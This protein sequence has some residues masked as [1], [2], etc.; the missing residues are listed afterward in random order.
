MSRIIIYVR[1]FQYRLLSNKLTTNILRNK[2]DASVSHLCT[3]CN[4]E[5]EYVD[6]LLYDCQIVQ[7]IWIA[8]IKWVKYILKQS[9][10]EIN[11]T[12]ILL[13]NYKGK[14]ELF[15][16]TVTLICKQYIY[17]SKCK[18][19]PLEVMKVLQKIHNI[20][21]IERLIAEKKKSTHKHNKKWE[22]YIKYVEI[23]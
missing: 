16:N 15:L 5:K 3:F 6:H 18:K 12:V 20:Y 14:N 11:K 23:M 9:N 21:I 22:M 4:E 7:K 13:G 1:F 17:A 2:W 19:E 8:V 10:L